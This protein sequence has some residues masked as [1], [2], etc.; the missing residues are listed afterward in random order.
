VKIHHDNLLGNSLIFL[1][2]GVGAL[3]HLI[4]TSRIATIFEMA[5]TARSSLSW[6]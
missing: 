1:G 3:A 5:P 6:K 2:Y 4:L